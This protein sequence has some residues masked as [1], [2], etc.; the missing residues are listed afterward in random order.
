MSMQ[1]ARQARK[2]CGIIDLVEW[3]N[4]WK[5]DGAYVDPSFKVDY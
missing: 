3:R 1:S 4:A 2:K 5:V